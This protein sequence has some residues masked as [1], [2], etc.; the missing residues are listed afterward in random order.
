MCPLS[1]PFQR[2]KLRQRPVPRVT[3][4]EVAEPGLTPDVQGFQ[5]SGRA[6]EGPSRK[7]P[8]GFQR[9]PGCLGTS[10][11]W[12]APAQ[13]CFKSEAKLTFAQRLP[14]PDTMKM[15]CPSYLTVSLYPFQEV[16]CGSQSRSHVPHSHPISKDHDGTGIQGRLVLK[17]LGQ[18]PAFLPSFL[19]V[20]F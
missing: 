8:W 19:F 6:G 14:C 2:W 10:L 3:E 11:T 15:E 18:C 5:L 1:A 9:P 12:P 16:S 20:L 7:F 4:R 17:P 13:S